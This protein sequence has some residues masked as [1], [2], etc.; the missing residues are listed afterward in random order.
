MPVADRVWGYNQVSELVASTAPDSAAFDALP[1]VCGDLQVQCYKLDFVCSVTGTLLR[2][3]G[4]ER[5]RSLP[6]FLR[7][8]LLPR[9]GEEVKP[10]IDCF[11][12]VGSVSLVHADKEQLDKDVEE[13][14]R[15]EKNMFV[16]E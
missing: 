14:R 6:S 7:F 9:G 4:L 2:L 8:D 3:E 5:I 15:I 16:V 10:T 12:A 13:V 11:T 1:A